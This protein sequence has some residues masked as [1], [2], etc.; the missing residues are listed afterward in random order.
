[1][2]DILNTVKQVRSTIETHRDKLSSEAATR[3]ALID[4]MLRILGWDTANLGMV[5][6]EYTETVGRVDYVLYGKDGNPLFSV[7][8][9]RL[10]SP[11]DDRVRRQA[12]GD[13]STNKAKYIV[14]TDGDL[15]EVLDH[16]LDA[17]VSFSIQDPDAARQALIMYNDGVDDIR[18]IRAP[19]TQT[20]PSEPVDNTSWI[21]LSEL[22]YTKGDKRPASVRFPDATTADV[23]S[24]ID[25]LNQ[26]ATWLVKKKH[27]TKKNCP[28]KTGTTRYLMNTEPKHH[29]GK[30]F[31]NVKKIGGLYLECNFSPHYVLV[32]SRYLIQQAG[33]NPSSF[34]VHPDM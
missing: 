2:K 9:K 17:I 5:I 20:K 11:L 21:P 19:V 22:A 24:W 18:P 34:G 7:E 29:S 30:Q 16:N 32:L 31:Q 12:A 10:G 13:R 33:L 15:W 3:Y 28:I 26:I 27:I 1:M 23:K 6:P 14:L 4:P 8:A 25:I